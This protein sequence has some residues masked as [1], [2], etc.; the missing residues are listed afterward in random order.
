MIIKNNKVS[1]EVGDKLVESVRGSLPMATLTID[2][3]TMEYAYAADKKFR[4]K[5]PMTTAGN[6][7][8]ERIDDDR[9]HYRIVIMN[10]QLENQ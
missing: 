5:T 3:V 6:A 9:H 2:H 8:P 10:E 1:L 7:Y 4:R